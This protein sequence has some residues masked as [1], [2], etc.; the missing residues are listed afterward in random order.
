MPRRP[1]YDKDDL[2]RRARDLFW[3]KGWAGTS[4]KD[5]EKALSL[6]PGSIYAAFGSKDELYSLALD[7]YISEGSAT[8]DR[9]ADELGPLPALQAY[10]KTIL[11]NDA[12]AA[13]ACMLAKTYLELSPQNHPLA[14]QAS[15]H[16]RKMENKFAT[17][18]AAAQSNDQIGA[19]H[20]PK[21]LAQRYQS[22]LMGLR[23]SAERP[24]FNA[25]KTAEDI[26][27]GLARL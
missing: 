13:R 9:L 26:S 23:L 4:L 17:L 14:E 15:A 1:T 16:L 12:A 20:E 6:N 2:I 10:P 5:L 19:E 21:F 18:F 11:E 24:D 3:R 27:R 7:R 22:D 8:L 25:F